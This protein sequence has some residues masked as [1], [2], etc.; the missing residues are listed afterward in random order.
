M[1]VAAICDTFCF[2]LFVLTINDSELS[3]LERLS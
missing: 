1:Y 3:S 2:D